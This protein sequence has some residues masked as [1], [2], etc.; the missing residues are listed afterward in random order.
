MSIILTKSVIQDQSS[1]IL[2]QTSKIYIRLAQIE[3]T[4]IL[5]ELWLVH[6]D[7][8]KQWSELYSYIPTAQSSWVNQ[9]I[10]WFNEKNHCILLAEDEYGNV[11]GYI[12]GSYHP[13]PVS[14]FEHYGS[15]NTITVV[16]EARGRGIGKKLVIRL[17]SWFKEHQIQHV[18]LHVDYHNDIALNLY[19]S[20]GFQLYQHRMILNLNSKS[21]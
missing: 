3:D 14:P 9:L 17:L 16:E 4:E 11:L 7:Y 12:H 5:A 18:S 15:L 20:V 13:W 2:D 6:R 1:K 21:I 8:H 10:T 19:R